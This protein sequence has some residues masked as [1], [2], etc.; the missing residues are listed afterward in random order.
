MV[1]RRPLLGM[2]FRAQNQMDNASLTNDSSLSRADFIY[3]HGACLTCNPFL[4][5]L[6][7]LDACA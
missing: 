7:L 3:E 5:V 4:I 6:I 2:A 1:T